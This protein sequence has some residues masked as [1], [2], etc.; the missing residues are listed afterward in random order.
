MKCTTLITLVLIILSCSSS[1][2][3]V[4][5]EKCPK[6]Y[7]NSFTKILNEKQKTVLNN[8][9][10]SFNEIRFECVHSSF[11]TH[12][13][14][15]EKFGKW[16]QAIYPSSRKHPILMWEKVDLFSDGKK[17]IVFTNGIEEWKHIYASV[18]VFDENEIDLLSDNSKEKEKLTNFFA[19]SIKNLNT[20]EKF[21]YELYW[22]MVDPDHLK[23]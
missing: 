14:M 9:T 10:I 6:I 23:L 1:Q 13:V 12:E 20:K 19:E 21:F 16:D 11:Y 22:K 4:K 5:D 15:F 7:K 8:D 2:K 3:A 17:Y 18:M